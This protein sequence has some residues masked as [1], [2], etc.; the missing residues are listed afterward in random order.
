MIVHV[1]YIPYLNMVPFHQ[2]FGV[3][4]LDVHGHSVTFRSCSPRVL[5]LEAE[6][7]RMDAGALSLVD[8]FRLSDEFESI[9][10]FGIGV[11]KP[12]NS[13]LFFSKKPIAEFRGVCSVT[14]ET[15]TSVRLLQ[16]LLE[17]RHKI[18]GVTFGRVAS[19]LLYDG[20]SE[21][22]LLIGDEALEARIKGIKGLPYV[23]DLGE[24]WHDW[25]GLPFV[26]AR[27]AVR[28]SIPE[29]VKE[30]LYKYIERS[31]EL[32]DIHKEDAARKEAEGRSRHWPDIIRYWEGFEYRLTPN[33][34][35]S[36]T[37]FKELVNQACL[38]A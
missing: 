29:N 11:K 38:T 17:R 27:W 26:F 2:G 16:V 3:G 32:M 36:I 30:A 1:G 7:G 25:H 35:Q 20:E 15:A 18:Q 9:G 19:S 21:G 6:S 34:L 23:T 10:D 5:G 28:K 31:L 33:H 37:R 13:V 22:L 12:A 24:E 4:S 14:D 8:F